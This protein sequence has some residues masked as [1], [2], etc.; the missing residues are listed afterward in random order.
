M[1]LLQYLFAVAIE[2]ITFHREMDVSTGAVAVVDEHDATH[3]AV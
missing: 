1:A 3:A 2:T